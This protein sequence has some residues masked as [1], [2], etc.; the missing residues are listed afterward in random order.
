MRISKKSRPL[1]TVNLDFAADNAGD[2]L[3]RSRQQLHID[4]GFVTLLKYD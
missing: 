2:T 4:F 1:Q 3:C